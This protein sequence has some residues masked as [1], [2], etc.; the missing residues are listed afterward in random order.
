MERDWLERVDRFA[1]LIHW[2]DFVL[3]PPRRA[4]RAEL[5]ERVYQDWYGVRVSGRNPTNASDK[6]A[7]L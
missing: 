7:C 2:L 1:G 5:A 6:S 4:D 3:E